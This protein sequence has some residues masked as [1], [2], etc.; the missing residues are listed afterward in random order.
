VAD[1]VDSWARSFDLHPFRHLDSAIGSTPHDDNEQ[2]V[3]DERD[4][5]T[6]E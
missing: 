4:L 3:I 6:V 2:N 5:M 1:K